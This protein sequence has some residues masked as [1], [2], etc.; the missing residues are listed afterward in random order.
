MYQ[1]VK[2]IHN[3]SLIYETWQ[4][5]LLSL[6]EFGVW[7][8]GPSSQVCL[9]SKQHLVL[10]GA[11]IACQANIYSLVL[12]R[13]SADRCRL[14]ANIGRERRWHFSSWQMW[15]CHVNRLTTINYYKACKRW[16]RRMFTLQITNDL[17]FILP[18]SD[19]GLKYVFLFADIS[20]FPYVCVC[21]YEAKTCRQLSGNKQ[22]NGASWGKPVIV[23]YVRSIIHF[24]GCWNPDCVPNDSVFSQA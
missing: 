20:H 13:Q 2:S 8:N 23:Y 4:G 11:L 5:H 6:W 7:L 16:L 21:V 15:S 12:S 3:W 19:L 14:H 10:Q 18:S 9:L 24:R 17:F 22:Q 1:T